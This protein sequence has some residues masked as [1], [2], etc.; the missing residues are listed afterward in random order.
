MHV[1]M[2]PDPLPQESEKDRK[3]GITSTV[4]VNHLPVMENESVII[5]FTIEYIANINDKVPIFRKCF[6]QRP[7]EVSWLAPSPSLMTSI[8]LVV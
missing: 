2:G 7:I 8:T 4:H 3:R 6:N 1:D 5:Q